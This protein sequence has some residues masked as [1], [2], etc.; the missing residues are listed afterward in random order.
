MSVAE[1]GLQARRCPLDQF[2]QNAELY[3]VTFIALPFVR[4]LVSGF[5]HLKLAL[6]MG[7]FLLAAGVGLVAFVL[8]GR[9]SFWF[10]GPTTPSFHVILPS[11]APVLVNYLDQY[12]DKLGDE[13]EGYQNHCLRTL[14]FAEEF[15][16]ADGWS[17][18]QIAERR[19]VVETALAFHDIALWSDGALNYLEPSA[20]QAEVKASHLSAEDAA[21]VRDIIVQ[22]HKF[23]PYSGSADDAV[24]NAVRKADWVDFTQS[25][26]FCLRSG[27]PTGN[28][29]EAHAH[30]PAAG[31]YDT[32]GKMPA[33]HSPDNEFAGVR[34]V[35]K[36]YKW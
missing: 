17:P 7:K 36:I 28:I 13:R 35:L 21:L 2:A 30:L 12:A 15:L 14:S 32:L 19:E 4:R 22:H 24:V 8:Y 25:A 1:T 3:N 5:V 9:Q 26:G 31:F 34:E 16:R 10:P 23:T 20:K 33:R 18:A 6:E 11:E 29:A 27:M